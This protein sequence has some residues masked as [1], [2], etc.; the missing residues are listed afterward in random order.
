LLVSD[1]EKLYSEAIDDLI[2]SLVID[3]DRDLRA[4]SRPSPS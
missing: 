3:L 1:P 2:A 4:R